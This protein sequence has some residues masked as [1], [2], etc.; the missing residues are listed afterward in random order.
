MTFEKRLAGNM[1]FNAPLLFDTGMAGTEG[2]L[3]RS[4]V[5]RYHLHKLQTALQYAALN[6]SFYR[7]L[8]K[9]AGVA[10][11]DARAIP[12]IEKFPLTEPEQV[13]AEPFRFLC[14][15]QSEIARIH[16]FVTSGTTGPRKKIF[17]T[18]SD[19]DRVV[20]FMAAGIGTA[21]GSGD[22]VNVWLPTGI[23]YG[24][25]DLLSR[26][27]EAVGASPVAAPMDISSENHLRLIA[28][29]R[30]TVIFGILRKALRLTRE[31]ELSHDLSRTGVHTLFLTAEY[32]P[33]KTRA[34]LQ[35][36]WNCR[37]STHYGL[38]EM[39]LGVAVECDAR[40]GYHFNEADLLVEII[41]PET[42]RPV[43]PGNEG[44][45]VFT[46]LTR[47]AM[48]LIRYRTR[49]ISRLIPG[50]CP[51]GAAALGKFAAVKKRIDNITRLAGGE[52]IYPSLIDCALMDM[53]GFVDYRAVLDRLGDREILRFRVE[54]NQA[55]QEKIPEIKKRLLAAPTLARCIQ[56]GAMA[57]PSIEIAASGEMRDTG[58]QKMRIW[59]MNPEIA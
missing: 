46:T 51:C 58:T 14:L 15:S 16:N 6:S 24:Q 28:E 5:E 10:P 9:K 17:W 11:E 2:A 44:E 30:V 37:V 7:D 38:T 26:G 42:G 4:D 22:T 21:A 32:L 25:A 18:Q 20:R 19:L 43:P 33:D 47:E 40:D 45:L 31:L 35:K 27:V 39:G 8:F 48:P 59:R 1:R 29:S 53:P 3:T 12:D 54:L 23:P 13:A 34:A 36:A 49:D 56:A 57:E 55:D 52:E 50:P 41:D